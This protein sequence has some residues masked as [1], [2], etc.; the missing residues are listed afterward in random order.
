MLQ[1]SLGEF[2]LVFIIGLIV[3][4]PLQLAIALKIVK[5]CFKLF[6]YLKS[7]IQ[8]EII[9]LLKSKVFKKNIIMIDSNRLQDLNNRTTQVI[10]NITNL[11][12]NP[13]TNRKENKSNIDI[14]TILLNDI[15]QFTCILFN[16]NKKIYP[17]KDILHKVK[18][19]HYLCD[20]NRYSS[21]S[22]PQ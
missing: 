11:E 10:N 18:R 5:Q 2:I 8:Y 21:K 15:N 20:N 6:N 12:A 19:S 3:L 17:D 7:I 14:L 22:D 9:F 4:S 1:F 16:I 13:Y